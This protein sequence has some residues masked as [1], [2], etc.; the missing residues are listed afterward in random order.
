M[1][2]GRIAGPDKLFDRRAG[3][4]RRIKLDA[5]YDAVSHRRADCVG[6]Q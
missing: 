3:G 5:G 1:R 6:Q 4:N 2:D